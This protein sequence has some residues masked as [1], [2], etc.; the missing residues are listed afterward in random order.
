MPKIHSVEYDQ[1]TQCNIEFNISCF[2]ISHE[3][4]CDQRSEQH[5]QSNWC[6]Q[7]KRIQLFQNYTSINS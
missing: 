6:K 2:E 3:L 5:F 7:M 4:W 1:H